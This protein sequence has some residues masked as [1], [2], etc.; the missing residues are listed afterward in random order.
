MSGRLIFVLIAAL[1][2]CACSQSVSVMQTPQ[3]VHPATATIDFGTVPLWREADTTFT[4]RLN[5]IDSITSIVMSDSDFTLLNAPLTIRK[6]D[7]TVT[8][9]IRY[10]PE[11]IANHAGSLLLLAG[12]DTLAAVSLK[13]GTS[14]FERHMGDSYVFQDSLGHL[15][16]VWISELPLAIKTSDSTLV[17]Q[18]YRSAQLIANGDWSVQLLSPSYAF[19]FYAFPVVVG[20]PIATFTP[21]DSNWSG[22]NT[23]GSGSSWH[24]MVAD[25]G[26]RSPSVDSVDHVRISVNLILAKTEEYLRAHLWE[27]DVTEAFTGNYSD[28]IGFFT[29]ASDDYQ[30]SQPSNNTITQRMN[31]HLLRFHLRR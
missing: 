11:S 5:R 12:K 26:W 17:D 10:Q 7:S 22:I 25:S 30:S 8:L 14:P 28:D 1:A 16:S 9:D 15:D 20:L 29:W 4:L 18:I 23:S 21:F 2:L 6:Q 19:P 24:D 3:V 27:S 13:G 31:Y